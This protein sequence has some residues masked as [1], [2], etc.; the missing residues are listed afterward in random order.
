MRPDHT[1]HTGRSPLPAVTV[2]RARP[3]RRV[4][5]VLAV[6]L[7]SIAIGALTVWAFLAYT[8]PDRVLDFAGL[9]QMCGIPMGR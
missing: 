4:A 1:G 6:A 2:A 3:G 5:T 9:L 7:A 8:H